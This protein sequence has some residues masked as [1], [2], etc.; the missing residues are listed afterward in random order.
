[1]S[2]F[3]IFGVVGNVVGGFFMG[4]GLVV[5]GIVGSVGFLVGFIFVIFGVLRV[6]E[7]EKKLEDVKVYCF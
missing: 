5:G 2:F 6:V 1:M 4:F 3:D 7:M